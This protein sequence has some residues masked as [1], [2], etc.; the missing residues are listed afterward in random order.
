VLE[1]ALSDTGDTAGTL[2]QLANEISDT[3]AE[4]ADAFEAEVKLRESKPLLPALLR[5]LAGA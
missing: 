4:C 5:M 3:M 2:Y 1:K